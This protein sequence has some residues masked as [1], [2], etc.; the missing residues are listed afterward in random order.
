LVGRQL[1]SGKSQSANIGADRSALLALTAHINVDPQNL[2]GTN[3][4]STASVCDWIGVTCGPTHNRVTALDSSGMGLS[5]TSPPHLGNLSFLSRLAMS[6]NNFHGL[7]PLQLSN[8]L[9]LKE[10]DLTINQLS[11]EI[12]EAIGHLSSLR[13]LALPFNK[14]SGSF[15]SSIFN[16]YSSGKVDLISKFFFK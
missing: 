2:L 7:L 1:C 12:P 14:L 6:N 11:G 5:G 15:P 4:T 8:L 16:I 9:R 10:I 3:W 13:R